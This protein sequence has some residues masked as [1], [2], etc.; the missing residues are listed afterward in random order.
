KAV[1][2]KEIVADGKTLP[3]EFEADIPQSSWV[4]VR[5]FP[6]VHTNPVFVH[7]GNKPI[8]ADKKSAE[9]CRDAVEV[10]WNA[11]KNQIREPERA[12][13]RAAYDSAKAF[14]EKAME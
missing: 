13:A 2:K 14:Y 3:L 8:R 1:A 6:S 9:W 7:V 11:K 12:A 4:A 5:I 10:C